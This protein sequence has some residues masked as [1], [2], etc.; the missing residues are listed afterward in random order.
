[1]TN[2]WRV[3]IILLTCLLASSYA[4]AEGLYLDLASGFT[5]F[6]CTICQGDNDG[7]WR[8]A[9][10]PNG[11][12]YTSPAFRAGLG[13]AWDKWRV[14]A[15]YLNAGQVKIHLYYTTG[16]DTYD[17][18][19]HRC[20]ANCSTPNTR[21]E[22]SDS[23]QGGEL[24]LARDFTIGPVKPF[25][26]VGG[27]VLFHIIDV[28][29]QTTHLKMHGTVPMGLIGGGLCYQWVCAETTYY[30]G[31]G[32][33]TEWSAGLPVSKEMFVSLVSIRIPITK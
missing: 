26:R 13:Y 5:Q 4:Q 16:D 15:S 25:V 14:Q 3:Y 6:T 18:A 31:F 32:G 9:G 12:R 24:S 22:T 28:N 11:I 29:F 33:G 2:V 8:Q 7:T 19:A 27:A 30:K 10:L 21:F 23:Y 1:M 20:L 17:K